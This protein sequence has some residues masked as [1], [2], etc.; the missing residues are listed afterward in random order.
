MALPFVIFGISIGNRSS[1]ELSKDENSQALS[2]L[3]LGKS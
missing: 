2:C 1:Q 3:P